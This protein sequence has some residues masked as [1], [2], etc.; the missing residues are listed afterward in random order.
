M[1]DRSSIPPPY[2]EK[3]FRESSPMTPREPPST[4][5]LRLSSSA[6][7]GRFDSRPRSNLISLVA[8]R[9]FAR[10]K[11]REHLFHYTFAMGARV[12][13]QPL[14]PRAIRRSLS[15]RNTSS[16]C[17]KNFNYFAE[18]AGVYTNS[19]TKNSR[20]RRVLAKHYGALGFSLS[21]VPRI[22]NQTFVRLDVT[23]VKRVY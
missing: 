3:L 9:R 19:G 2:P 21:L 5:P 11:V 7:L 20:S 12:T 17:A 16:P 14:Q 22:I 6:A 18:T 8:P 15:A 13:S 10:N 4:S 23:S 1:R